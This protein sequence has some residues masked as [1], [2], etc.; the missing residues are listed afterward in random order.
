MLPELQPRIDMAMDI[1]AP[2]HPHFE[3]SPLARHQAA[4][5]SISPRKSPHF[6]RKESTDWLVCGRDSSA[7]VS[8]TYLVLP[9][10]VVRLTGDVI[11]WV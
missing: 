3:N 1:P 7:V 4:F 5:D 10:V 2:C 6:V 11:V 8:G 9:M